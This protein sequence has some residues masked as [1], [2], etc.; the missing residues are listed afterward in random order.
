L[1]TLAQFFDTSDRLIIYE[2][3]GAA[4]GWIKSIVIPNETPPD[5]LHI[6]ISKRFQ[7]LPTLL[8]LHPPSQSEPTTAF[9][10]NICGI[11]EFPLPESI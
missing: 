5:D 2:Q 4:A 1:Q 7:H 8:T 6:E 10:L 3:S 11:P 9:C